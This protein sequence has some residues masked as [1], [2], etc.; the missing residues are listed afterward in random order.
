MDT[1]HS[2][3][4]QQ[5]G[6]F[7]EQLWRAH[8]INAAERPVAQLA[9]KV[10]QR[11]YEVHLAQ[12]HC[13][14]VA[15]QRDRFFRAVHSQVGPAAVRPRA[16]HVRGDG[17]GKGHRE[18]RRFHVENAANE[19]VHGHDRT[20]S[21]PFANNNYCFVRFSFFRRQTAGCHIDVSKLFGLILKRRSNKAV[22]VITVTS[23]ILIYL[24]VRQHC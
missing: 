12:N 7:D 16:V 4:T 1:G 19:F 3:L 23:L 22:I 2:L 6:V 18:Q 20:L 15:E 13:H 5:F 24:F 10:V 17:N 21:S 14:C 8:G 9:V 11:V